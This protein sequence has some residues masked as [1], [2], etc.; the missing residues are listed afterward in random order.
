MGA[1]EQAFL[2]Q[3]R[4]R[5]GEPHKAQGLLDDRVHRVRAGM[6]R[7]EEPQRQDDGRHAAEGQPTGDLPVDVVVLFMNNHATGFGDGRVQQISADGGCRV[8]SEPKQDRRHQRTA[9]YACHA[10]NEADD[11]PGNNQPDVH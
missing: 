3:N 4:Q 10:D 5:R 1:I 2:E 7:A 9:P 6:Q 11:Q 8:D